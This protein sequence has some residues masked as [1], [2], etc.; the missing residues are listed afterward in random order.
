MVQ[1]TATAVQLE[2]CEFMRHRA[3]LPEQAHAA[4]QAVRPILDVWR[5]MVEVDEIVDGRSMLI[6]FAQGSYVENLLMR[7]DFP[8]ELQNALR[9]SLRD[10]MAPGIELPSP[11][12]R[13]EAQTCA[14]LGRAWDIWVGASVFRD[15]VRQWAPTPSA[16]D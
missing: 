9:E 8:W 5:Y 11:G 4:S 14:I 1:D 15:F 13:P 2:F 6:H 7:W 16:A 10:A 3:V 12:E